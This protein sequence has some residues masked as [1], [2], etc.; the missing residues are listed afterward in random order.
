MQA[1]QQ[2]VTG[3][4]RVSLH[5][6]VPDLVPLFEQCAIFVN[7]MRFGAGV[8]LKTVEA[9]LRGLPLLSTTTGAKGSGLLDGIHCRIENEPQAFAETVRHLL[10][11]TE[12]ARRLRDNAG[13]FICQA[14]N[15][16]ESLRMAFNELDISI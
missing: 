15:Q 6:N 3:H 11:N 7:P 9:A 10:S 1:F 8:K 12:T 14:Y 4:A 16:V 2:E 13:A 5:C